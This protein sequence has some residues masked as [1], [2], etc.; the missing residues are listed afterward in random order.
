[1]TI[2]IFEALL[3]LAAASVAARAAPSWNQSLYLANGGYWPERVA[4]TVT[5]ALA[6]NLSGVPVEFSLPGLAGAGVTSLRVCRADGIELLFELRNPQGLEKHTGT[7]SADDR[8]IVPIECAPHATA[9]VFVYA[10]NSQAWPLREFLPIPAHSDIAR[11]PVS[12]SPVEKLDLKQAPVPTSPPSPGLRAWAEVRVRNPGEKPIGAALVRI[13]LN[14]ALTRLPG[15]PLDCAARAFSGGGAILPSFAL[16]GG[17]DFLFSAQLTPLSEQWFRL[18]FQDATP[19]ETQSAPR[20]CSRL[21]Q[22][23]ANL[24]PDASFDPGKTVPGF[25]QRPQSGGPDQVA[26]RM[27]RGGPFGSRCLQLTVRHNPQGHWIGWKSRDIPVQ[28]GATYLLSG[29]LQAVDLQGSAAIYAHFHDPTGALTKSG[30]MVGTQPSVSGSSDWVNS[31]GFFRAPPDAASIRIHLTANTQGTLRHDGLLLC[32]VLNGQ[33]VN[34]HWIGRKARTAGLRVSQVNPLVKVFPQ[35]ALRSQAHKVGVELARNEYEPFELALRPPRGKPGRLDLSVSTLRNEAGGTLP[36]VEIDRVGFV[37]IDYP[38][39]YYSTDVPDWCRKVP[40]GAGAT[41]GW[42]GWWP[43]PLIPGPSFRLAADRTQPVWFTVHAPASAAPGEYRAQLACRFD[44]QEAV[45]IPLTVRVLP[46]AL[47][48]EGHLHAIFDFRFGPGGVFGSGARSLEDRHRWLRLIANHRLGINLIEPPPRFNYKEGK[49]TM[50]ARAFDQ[51][52]R[53]CFDDLHMNVAYTPQFFYLFG[54]AYPPKKLFGLAPL[55]PEWVSALK[56]AYQLFS[57]HVREKGWRNKFVYYISDE[58]HFQHPFII[59]QMRKLC[60]IVHQVSPA[61]PIYSSTWRHCPAWDDSLDIWGI[62]QYGCFPVPEMRRLQQAGKQMWFTC[63]GQMA[64]DTPF[65]ATERLLPYYCFKYGVHGFE[66]W[67]LAWWTYNPWQTGWHRFIRQSDE[68]KRYYWVRYPDG[69][70]YLTYPGKPVGVEGPVSTI[71]LEE[72]REGLEDYE[73]LTL[74]EKLAA[75]AKTDGHP[76]AS[77]ER[78]LAMA[79]GLVSIPN[80][81]GLRSTQILPDPSRVP[82]VRKAVNAALVELSR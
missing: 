59:E 69:D 30:A 24:V 29:W 66:F 76:S 5:N 78:A 77:A 25:W 31:L 40:R 72:V 6:Q 80:A 82:A 47:P 52:A 71:R 51:E 9:T 75:K 39:A 7:L 21:L 38:S 53:Y 46:F 55:T 64:I 45:T 20:A 48:A 81:G 73:A 23:R 16:G 33:V 27:V 35:T 8:L 54:W 63:D 26:A 67:G 32:R 41:D 58:P 56:Q 22:S 42:S 2:C 28:P 43:D 74:L 37:P 4:I 10:D 65:L 18:G 36:P 1:M 50:D 19:T 62:G 49:V 14:Q 34:V 60:T 44:G 68:G 17:A 11:L 61:I 3:M 13:S 70:G 15:M 79:R 57:D 12:E